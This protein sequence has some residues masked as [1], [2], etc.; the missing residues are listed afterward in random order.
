MKIL[1]N[2]LK[3]FLDIP[4]NVLEVTNSFVTEVEEFGPLS[5]INNLVIGHVLEKVKHENAD[6][7]SVLQVDLG[8]GLTQQIVCGA[9]NVDVDQYVVIATEGAVLP[10]DFV[11]KKSKIRGV[12]SN[13]MVCS[14]TELGIDEKHIPEEFKSGI[15][16][17]SESKEIGSN[18]LNHLSL[19]GFIMELSLTPNRSDLLSHYGYAQDLA[20]ALDTKITLPS[21]VIS[22]ESKSNDLTV[23]IESNNTNSYYARAL[24]DLTI[25]ESPWWLKNFLLNLNCQPV[26]NVVDITNY[27][28]YTYGT[29]MHAFDANK[30]GSKNIVIKD[31]NETIEV[32]TLD[33]GKYKLTSDEV[34]VTNSKDAMAIGGVMGLKNSMITNETTNVILEI[35][36]FNAKSVGGTSKKLGLK[37]DSSLRFERGI[38]EAI[39][40]QALNHATYLLQKYANAKV[41]K[42]IA[43]EV[44]TIVENPFIEINCTEISNKIGMEISKEE[45]ISILKR[46]NYD[47]KDDSKLL[48]KAPSYRH[49]IYHDYDV[50]E[51]VVRLFGMDQVPNK[52]LK[53]SGLGSLSKKQHTVRNLRHYLANL[54]F[55]EVVTYSLLNEN[56]VK[57][58]NDLGGI[59]SILKP[60]TID[61]RSL[62]QSII[63][64]LVDTVNYN[65]ART[66]TKVNLF[67]IGH[68]FADGLEN[69]YLSVALTA[70][71]H[72][73][74]WKKEEVQVDFYYLSGI[75]KNVFELMNIDYTLEASN[76]EN[77]HPYQQANIL[78]KGKIVGK[79]GLIHPTVVSKP[80]FVFEID[81]DLLDNPNK[82]KY[83]SISKYP[84]VERDIAIVL[85]DEVLMSEVLRLINQTARKQIVS[86]DV[87][88]IYKGEH[89][90]QGFK[91]VAIRL[92]FNDPN[93]TLEGNDVDKLVNKILK[94]IEFELD[95]VIRS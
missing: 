41:L 87:F 13:G 71:L 82:F 81:L 48:V 23:K 36:S 45:I 49:D 59:V 10:G 39:I 51:E 91:S 65:R 42:G 12:E 52:A 27:I 14:L 21:F 61:R 7:L 24:E 26:N 43:S 9:A 68:V 6:T 22:E 25:T 76:Y 72:N 77:F 46:L 50:L 44:K 90:E 75:L 29:P 84:N 31:N 55:N 38:D 67:E 8:K 94:R 58:F 66:L 40:L 1:E 56:N 47:I 3:Q 78:V 15:Y 95:G 33:D 88:D 53:V 37:S 19:D 32:E 86:A 18:A 5:D 30:F 85:K 4:N 17:F 89:I 16:Y 92:V 2:N 57:K 11:I 20:A 80:I 54:G 74:L 73:N 62:R 28:L 93:K 70:P 35:A 83:E 64:G 60:L 63:N 69:N 79:I 34:I